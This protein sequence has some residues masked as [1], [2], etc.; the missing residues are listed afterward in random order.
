MAWHYNTRVEALWSN[1]EEAN[2]WGW[3][4]GAWRKFDDDEDDACTNFAIITAHAK[5][6]NRAVDAFVDGERLK[7]IYVW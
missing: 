4:D 2:A 3:M 5:A 1:Y 6:G 7:E